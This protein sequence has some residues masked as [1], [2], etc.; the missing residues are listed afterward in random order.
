[1]IRILKLISGAEVV[2]ELIRGDEYGIVL[3]YPLQI[4]YKY[5]VSSFPSINLSKYIMFAGE[6]EVHFPQS[7]IINTVV[8]RATFEDYYV[9]AVAE[10]KSELDVIIDRQLSE[11]SDVNVWTREQV[12][13]ALLEDMPTPDLAN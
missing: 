3:K 12:F 5:Y 9:R 13:E 6:D 8:P 2:G 10:V 1:M 4:N 11:M 7:S